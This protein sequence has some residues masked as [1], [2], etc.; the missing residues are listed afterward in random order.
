MRRQISLCGFL[1]IT[2]LSLA[3]LTGCSQEGQ[4]KRFIIIPSDD[5]SYSSEMVAGFQKNIEA[6]GGEVTVEI[7]KNI[8]AEAQVSVLQKIEKEDAD[9]VVISGNAELALQ[10]EIQRLCSLDIPVVAF[11]EMITSEDLSI[12]IFPVKLLGIGKEFL[13]TIQKQ[14]SSESSETC[15]IAVLSSNS[16]QYNESRYVREIRSL[17]EA[18]EYPQ[19]MLTEIAYGN[20]NADKCREKVRHLTETY[21]DLDYVIC[22]TPAATLAAS[23]FVTE[24]GLKEEVGVVGIGMPSEMLDYVGEEKACK[25]LLYW[26]PVKLG[27]LAAQAA[28]AVESNTWKPEIGDTLK[29][30][31]YGEFRVEKG[32][33]EEVKSKVVYMQ[34]AANIME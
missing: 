5:G 2:I 32:Q 33:E 29:T 11:N 21:P 23:E 22:L 10:E 4:K 3:V 12:Q 6:A 18:G 24:Q 15:Q 19:I 30:T 7:P 8:T 20:N 26:E 28:M 17:L 9:C 1:I 14:R 34:E 31:E 27:A 13:E 16:F 25:K